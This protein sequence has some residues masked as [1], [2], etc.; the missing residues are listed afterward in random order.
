MNSVVFD[1][2]PVLGNDC[3]QVDL[4]GASLSS[5]VIRSL[6]ISCDAI[7]AMLGEHCEAIIH[8]FSDIE[9]SI[10]YIA[11]NV[12]DRK[13]G[14]SITDLGH[15]MITSNMEQ[16]EPLAYFAK[17]P[18]GHKLKC[19]STLI[20]DEYSNKILG[21]LCINLDIEVLAGAAA[22]LDSLLGLSNPAPV[23]ERF[24]T[25][26]EEIVVQKTLETVSEMGLIL[27]DLNT[28]ERMEIVHTLN[29]RGV[30][31]FKSA[32]SIVA[33]VLGVSRATVYN[34]LRRISP[35]R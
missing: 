17:S 9:H 25:K 31:A 21:S 34:Y 12:T 29:E 26:P 18:R 19:V 15:S 22:S 3:M 11:G 10:I 30:F 24:D 2:D 6:K 35:V 4:I 27:S 20:R 23:E 13:V 5:D 8:D 14:G 33:E 7:V 1:S 28:D 16:T 32:H